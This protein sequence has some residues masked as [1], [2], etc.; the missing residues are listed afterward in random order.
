M[1]QLAYDM[2][3]ATEMAALA[4]WPLI[5]CGDKN[6]IDG[7]AVTAMRQS[8]NQAPMRGRIIIGE[9]EIDHA[10]M[11]FIDEELGLGVGPEVDI[12]VDPIEGTRMVS[13]GQHNALSVLACAPRG[14]L[15]H[16]PDMY[17][18]K[19][20]VRPE[21]K[22]AID[23]TRSLEDNLRS[24]AAAL[25]KPLQ[26]LQVVILDKPRH[27]ADIRQLNNLGV[28]VSILPD[29]DVAGS[30]MLCQT[31]SELDVMY[32]IGG[33]PEGVLSACAVK[34]M[35]G[36][37]QAMLIDSLDAKGWSDL[38]QQTAQQE[39]QRC[40]HM[41]VEVNHVYTLNQ[42]VHTDE[43]LFSATGVTKGDLTDGVRKIESKLQTQSLFLNGIDKTQR[44]INTLHER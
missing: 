37:M 2:L 39:R 40:Q 24:V 12:A 16:A 18:R 10:P 25:N 9:G 19:L 34:I 31:N 6:Q 43:I 22:G 21:A 20:V 41:G 30:I 35:G 5:G 29:G 13:V 33:A 38:N 36:D 28:K 26:Q 11:L 27:Q 23:L 17:M 14:C 1:Q 42:M 7:A 8:L 3:R 4:A 32:T 15:F 44:L